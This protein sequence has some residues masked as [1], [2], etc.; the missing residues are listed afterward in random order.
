MSQLLIKEYMNLKIME[1]LKKQTSFKEI[2]FIQW[3]ILMAI[4]FTSFS[5]RKQWLTVY[6]MAPVGLENEVFLHLEE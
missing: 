6:R 1:S 2:K 4:N 5:M 3:K